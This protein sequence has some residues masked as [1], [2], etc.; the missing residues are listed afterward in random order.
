MPKKIKDFKYKNEMS[1]SDF[2]SDLGNVGFQSIELKKA[3]DCVLKMKKNKAKIYLTFT[4]NMVTSG[5][6][7]LFAQTIEKKICDVIVTTVGGIEEDI[8]KATGENFE[9]GSFDSNDYENYENGKNRVGNIFINN[10]AYL[11]FED[12]INAFLKK[13]YK[14]KPVWTPSEI[15]FEIGKNLKDKNSILYQATKNNIPIFCPSITDG[16]FGYHLFLFQQNHKDF[17]I[18]IIKDFKNIVFSSS[19]DEKKAV[20]CLGG[21]I[22]KHHAILSTLLNGGA[23]F[24]VYMTTARETSGSLSGATTK[25]AKSWGKIKDETDAVTCIGDTTIT[26]PLMISYVFENV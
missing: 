4:S 12:W 7:G 18:D 22:S 8:M 5:L 23:D 14:I 13:I 10:Q 3:A 25:E 24:A 26:F 15:F 2:V 9:I 16:A 17:M 20:I 19:Y 21:G 11:R 6:R 1:I